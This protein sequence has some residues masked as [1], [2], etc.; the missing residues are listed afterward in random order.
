MKGYNRML[1]VFTRSMQ[2]SLTDY[3]AGK[4]DWQSYLFKVDFFC[5]Q[6]RGAIFVLELN[7]LID[8]SKGCELSKHVGDLRSYYADQE[9]SK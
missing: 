3:R 2:Q 6:L 7:D 1:E 8:R 4:L 5:D 9:V